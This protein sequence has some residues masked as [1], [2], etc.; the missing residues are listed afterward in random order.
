METTNKI[1]HTTI[2][3]LPL[4]K[5]TSGIANW[6]TIQELIQ[7]GSLL[8]ENYPD[9]VRGSW[10]GY[11][12]FMRMLTI[13]PLNAAIRI[14]SI[15]KIDTV[16]LQI[17][18]EVLDSFVNTRGAIFDFTK[19]TLKIRG[20]GDIASSNFNLITFD[21]EFEVKERAINISLGDV[22]EIIDEMEDYGEMDEE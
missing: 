20:L 14:T 12:F 16:N 21:V 4:R 13:E 6:D 2:V 19:P 10:P 15:E 9:F 7:N 22:Q 18:Y 17:T 5:R 3:K 11:E 8:G 1:V